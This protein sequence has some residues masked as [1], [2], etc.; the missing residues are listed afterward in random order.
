MLTLT[1]FSKTTKTKGARDPW[2]QARRVVSE[3]IKIRTPS[4]IRTMTRISAY[5]E[6]LTTA[7]TRGAP[8]AIREQQWLMT[9]LDKKQIL[10]EKEEISDGSLNMKQRIEDQHRLVRSITKYRSI[11]YVLICSEIGRRYGVDRDQ[12]TSLESITPKLIDLEMVKPYFK[13][14]RGSTRAREAGAGEVG[15]GKPPV[16]TRWGAGQSGN[17]SGRRRQPDDAWESF[18][19]GLSRAFAIGKDGRETKMAA[20]EVIVA[21]L[22]ESAMKGNASS[23]LQVRRLLTE[24]DE[25]ELLHPPKA[26][27]RRRPRSAAS[28]VSD[29]ARSLVNAQMLVHARLLRR[30]MVTLLEK[31]HAPVPDVETSLERLCR[32]QSASPLQ[33]IDALFAGLH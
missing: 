3:R 27:P 11:A 5:L 28:S 19:S 12:M 15:Y 6:H 7:A 25:R 30:D 32:A 18:R 23:R 2:A 22:F 24:L 14:V 10:E 29:E 33:A 8:A 31:T 21:R 13:P 9:Y 20:G 1:G 4:G 26:R 16:A 17:P